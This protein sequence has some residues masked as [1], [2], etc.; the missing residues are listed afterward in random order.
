MLWEVWTIAK[1]WMVRPSAL[2]CISDEVAAYHLDRAVTMFGMALEDDIQRHTRD[3]KDNK[4]AEAKARMVLDRWLRESPTL[5]PTA[6]AQ[7]KARAEGKTGFRD[8]AEM[9]KKKE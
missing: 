5:S 8:P 2:L 6:E 4:S 1:T 7:A 3:A 9:L